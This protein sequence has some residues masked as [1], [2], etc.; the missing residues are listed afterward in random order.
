VL[1][2]VQ[3]ADEDQ[4]HLSVKARDIV[5]NHEDDGS[6]L[7]GNGDGVLGVHFLVLVGHTRRDQ[8]LVDNA[9][10]N[11]A[12]QLNQQLTIGELSVTKASNGGLWSDGVVDPLDQIFLGLRSNDLKVVDA[13]ELPDH[14]QDVLLVAGSD[15]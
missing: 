8:V 3:R 9:R 11:R 2:V 12:S 10:L 4:K 15:V 14:S 6:E 13:H 1:E 7:A 5:P